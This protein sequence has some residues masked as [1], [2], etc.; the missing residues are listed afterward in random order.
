MDDVRG[1]VQHG[2]A[3]ETNHSHRE[4]GAELEA[5]HCAANHRDQR[6]D[7]A[8]HEHGAQEGEILA[9]AMGHEHEAARAKRGNQGGA[10]DSARSL[11]IG[12]IEQR[13]EDQGFRN[14]VG[15][16]GEVLHADR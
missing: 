7:K 10:V 4:P 2:D 8:P 12:D 16:I 9:R 3:G 15:R 6:Q 1:V 13:H 5:E 14:H 11:C